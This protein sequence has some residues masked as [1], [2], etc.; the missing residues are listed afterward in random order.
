MFD[1]ASLTGMLLFFFVCCCLGGCGLIG[2]TCV[3]AT[4]C[5]LRVCLCGFVR[6]AVR[7]NVC[8][9]VRAQPKAAG[10]EAA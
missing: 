4:V 3:L 10:E 1:L 6:V 5:L 8:A 7:A 9:R 2:V